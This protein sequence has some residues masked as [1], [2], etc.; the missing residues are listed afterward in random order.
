MVVNNSE[1]T[2][3]R[4]EGQK[5]A[6]KHHVCCPHAPRVCHGEDVPNYDSST[7]SILASR[8]AEANYQSLGGLKQYQFNLLQRVLDQRSKISLT[9]LKSRCRQDWLLLEALKGES[10]SCFSQLLE[11][12]AFLAFSSI[13]N[14]VSPVSVP[15][16]TSSLTRTPFHT[17]NDIGSTRRSCTI[18]PSQKP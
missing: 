17:L 14:C 5:S 9:G 4:C 8:V 7:A 6:H 10:V 18:S 16:I 2:L 1:K 3:K 11:A 12:P 13:C 15:I